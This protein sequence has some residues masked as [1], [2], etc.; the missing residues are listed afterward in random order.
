MP[1]IKSPQTRVKV[2]VGGFNGQADW[3]GL[4]LAAGSGQERQG[5]AGQAATFGGPAYN[6]G[7]ANRVGGQVNIQHGITPNIQ[8]RRTGRGAFGG[9]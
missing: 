3:P 2:G 4:Q 5:L 9:G 1:S 7:A 6:V 8:Q